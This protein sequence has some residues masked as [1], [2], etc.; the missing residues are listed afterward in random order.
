MVK[1]YADYLWCIQVFDEHISARW[2][3]ELKI[4]ERA[5]SQ[6][7]AEYTIAELKHK[8]KLYCSTGMVTVF[9]AGVVKNDGALTEDLRLDLIAAAAPLEEIPDI[10]KDWHPGS[11]EKVLDLVHPSLYSLVYGRS[12][13]LSEAIVGVE[14]CVA[15]CGFGERLN[16]PRLH[17]KED[18]DSAPED[19][20]YSKNFQWLP[21]DVHFTEDGSPRYVFQSSGTRIPPLF[22]HALH[23]R[24]ASV[25]QE[26]VA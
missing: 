18:P 3:E 13:I 26:V 2:K 22:V 24:K 7:M 14:D 23:L 21:C 11:D 9:D 20:L 12:R 16:R 5:F 6:Q 25:H 8:T 4:A 19:G 1:S 15:M 17:E 10:H